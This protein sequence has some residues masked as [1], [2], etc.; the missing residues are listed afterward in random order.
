MRFR[1][2]PGLVLLALGL[3]VAAHGSRAQGPAAPGGKPVVVLETSQGSIEIELDAQKAPISTENFLAYVDAGAYDGTIFHRVIPG[4]MIQGGGF[5]ESMS[6]KSTRGPIKNEFGNGL[7]NQ[8]GTVAM[9]RTNDPHSATAQFFINLVDND[10]LNRPP[11][12]A[13]FGRVTS[14]MDVV[15]KI[16]AVKTAN[17]GGHQNVPVEAV[18]IQ[19]AR[20]K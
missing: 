1:S 7:T 16:A 9:A 14:G 20:R 17:K 4:F 2:V 19:K 11:G 15:D 5:D 12:Y 13:V 8:R 18:K 3:L 6:Q 10:F